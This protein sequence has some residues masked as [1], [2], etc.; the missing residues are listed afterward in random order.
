MVDLAVPVQ[1][2][3]MK[4]E[5]SFS[6]FQI[7]EILYTGAEN[8]VYYNPT[9]TFLPPGDLTFNLYFSGRLRDYVNIELEGGSLSGEDVFDGS[10]KT[11]ED[12]I[13]QR[14]V[15]TGFESSDVMISSGYYPGFEGVVTRV[16]IP[17]Q[18]TSERHIST[19]LF[20][21]EIV[22][23]LEL[24]PYNLQG[25]GMV[26]LIGAEIHDYYNV[27][28]GTGL[29]HEMTLAAPSTGVLHD[30]KLA[31]ARPLRTNFEPTSIE[32]DLLDMN[33]DVLDSLTANPTKTSWPYGMETGNI[34]DS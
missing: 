11:Y 16:S 25:I 13:K 29:N 8:P 22:L 10:F 3:R 18:S 31:V 15:T 6:G 1:G 28:V 7:K 23:N 4:F 14:L 17:L 9:Q 12:A 5:F 20:A 24:A 19:S 30:L 2:N 21:S 33:G 32:F 27:M 26:E 34:T